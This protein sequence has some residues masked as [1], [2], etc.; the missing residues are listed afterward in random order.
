MNLVSLIEPIN[1]LEE[2]KHFFSDH[3]YN[4]QLQYSSDVSQL[5][6]QKWGLP[7]KKFYNFAYE[8][9]RKKGSLR[10]HR[11]KF[12]NEYITEKCRSLLTEIGVKESIYI[13]FDQHKVTRCS[14]SNEKIT[15]RDPVEFS[16]EI[17]INQTL[18]HEIQTHFLRNLNQK[19][20]QWTYDRDKVDHALLRTEEGL[21]VLHSLL[22]AEDKEVIRPA[23]YYIA[24]YYAQQ[25]S[26]ADVFEHL[27]QLG[28]DDDFSWRLCLRTKRGIE[29]TSFP[30]GN[31]K[32]VCY[33]EGVIQMANW[34]RQTQNHVSDLYYGKIFI[35]ELN[36]RLK[37]IK[38]YH[39]YMPSFL[40]NEEK[41][42]NSIQA[43]CDANHFENIF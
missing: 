31:T 28:L 26:F 34:I 24:V 4:P 42:R 33:L 29:D 17:E 43:I 10:I 6:L 5:P 37:T 25:F 40:K 11:K 38:D 2:K 32:D 27:T 22:E 35:E 3:T 21:A 19:K 41:Y 16:S 9:L 12:A 39:I 23:A 15:F 8:L 18:N 13:A 7:Q 30:G 36:D 20:Q 1:V 14:V